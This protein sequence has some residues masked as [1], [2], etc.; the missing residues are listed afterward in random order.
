M[1]G[2]TKF[3]QLKRIFDILHG[4]QGCLWDK[5]QTYSSLVGHLREEVR[6]L[7]A[8]VKSK[9]VAHLKEEL[10]D[11]LLLVMFYAQ[12]AKKDKRFDIEDVIEYLCKKLK[13]RHPHVFA[14]VQ[15]KSAHQ[16]I[17]NWNMIKAKEKRR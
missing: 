9:R 1:P 13:R 17:R 11:V 14:G 7:I 15:V 6:E 12:L 4:P 16:I 3:T 10:G 5:K 2:T 8:A